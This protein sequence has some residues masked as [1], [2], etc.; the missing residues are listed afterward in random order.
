[1]DSE[2]TL[3]TSSVLLGRDLCAEAQGSTR[4]L[5][6]PIVRGC[7]VEPL[8][9]LLGGRNQNNLTAGHNKRGSN[10]YGPVVLILIVK[11]NLLAAMRPH[12]LVISLLICMSFN[13]SELLPK[14]KS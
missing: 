2:L 1:M 5:Q 11:K 9:Q 10:F 3:S 4:H 13:M 14:N 6:I 12:T 7:Q 8:N